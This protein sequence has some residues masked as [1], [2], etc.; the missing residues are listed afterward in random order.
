MNDSH[1]DCGVAAPVAV[2]PSICFAMASP[3]RTARFSLPSM[4]ASDIKRF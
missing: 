3:A 4:I 2:A 1:L